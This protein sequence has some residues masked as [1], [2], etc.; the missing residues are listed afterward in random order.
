MYPAINMEEKGFFGADE[1]ILRAPH[2]MEF[3]KWMQF[4]L[5]P[6]L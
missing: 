1:S 6:T 5:M 2:F 4:D 3:V